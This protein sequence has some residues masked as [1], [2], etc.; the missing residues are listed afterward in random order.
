MGLDEELKEVAERAHRK[1][2][3][4]IGLT[5][6]VVA[7]FLALTT[8]LG[9]R[10]HTEETI[11]ETRVADQWA[12]YQAKNIRSHLYAADAEIAALLGKPGTTV[13]AKFRQSAQTQ[14]SDA[15]KISETAKE[16][17]TEVT[18]VSRSATLFDLGE[19]CLEVAIVLCSVSLLAETP[20][21][22]KLSFLGSIAGVALLALGLIFQL[23]R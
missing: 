14:K 12:F 11:L 17:E 9:H 20:V 18:A 2:E 23:R 7:A 19:I 5:M 22:W 15:D 4:R 3:K 10:S 1:E 16:L 6:A 8:M 13:A 21:Y